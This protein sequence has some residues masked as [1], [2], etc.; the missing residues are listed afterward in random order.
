MSIFANTLSLLSFGQ[1]LLGIPFGMFQSLSLA[2]ANEISPSALHTAAAS[3]VNI[4]WLLG[5]LLSSA[6]MLLQEAKTGYWAWRSAFPLVLIFAITLLV[7]ISALAP[8]SPVWLVRKGEVEKAKEVLSKLCVNGLERDSCVTERLRDI[9]QTVEEESRSSTGGWRQVFCGVNRRRTLLTCGTWGIQGLVGTALLGMSAYYFKNAG[10]DVH[11][12][13][14]LTLGRHN[15]GI[16]GTIGSW[17]LMG[18][19]GRR[20]VLLSGL[21][22]AC[23]L[24]V[25]IGG[26]GIAPST[27][28]SLSWAVSILLICFS[29]VYNVSIAPVG[30]AI[31]PELPSNQMRQ[32][33]L[34]T[35]RVVYLLLNLV[36]YVLLPYMLNPDAWDCAAK[37]GFFYFGTSAVCL[38]WAYFYIP[39]TKPWTTSAMNWLFEHKTKARSFAKAHVPS[40]YYQAGSKELVETPMSVNHSV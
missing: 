21:G 7:F 13:L 14:F 10:L 20:T 19:F 33:T 34:S 39:E 12:S 32:K 15:L 37:T 27:D 35:A 24:Q 40:D 18:K 1:F 38:A 6:V 25:T 3:N 8:E 31:L 2:Y 17:F 22:V 30:Y 11:Q 29:L 36:N 9:S 5:Q 28:S 26:L 16:F 23:P 4:D